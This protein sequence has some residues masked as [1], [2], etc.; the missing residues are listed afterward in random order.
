MLNKQIKIECES[1]EVCDIEDMRDFQGNLKS[2]SEIQYEKLKS[3][4]I[5]EGFSF[6]ISIWK[7]KSDNFIL[8][9][10]QRRKT[11]V[12]MREQGWDIPAVPVNIVKANSIKQA[13]R[14]L[15]T[16]AGS[17]GKVEREGL[18]DFLDSSGLEFDEIEEAISF[19]T[20]DIDMFK[21]EYFGEENPGEFDMKKDNPED[22][23]NYDRSKDFYSIRVEKVP[24]DDKETVINLINNMFIENK[25]SSYKAEAY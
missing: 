4:I 24:P 12:R 14:K 17:Y 19:P 25:M 5:N 2:L 3:E 6:P 20:I 21:A 10:H 11:L 7:H 16:G 1:K 18:Y 8:D 9:G 13:K 15:L 23:D 22:M